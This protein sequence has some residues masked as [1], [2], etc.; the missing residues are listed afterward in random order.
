MVLERL[1]WRNQLTI[2]RKL[3]PGRVEESVSSPWMVFM[4]SANHEMTAA[5]SGVSQMPSVYASPMPMLP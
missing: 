1:R 3:T 2:L 4:F 5:M